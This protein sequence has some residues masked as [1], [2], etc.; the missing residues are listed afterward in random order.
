MLYQDLVALRSSCAGGTETSH[1]MA[2]SALKTMRFVSTQ[3]VPDG[4][5]EGLSV[6][7]SALAEIPILPWQ[8][9]D[10]KGPIGQ[11]E[12]QVVMWRWRE[13]LAK[14][15]PSIYELL[16]GQEDITSLVCRACPFP[17][18]YPATA[19]MPH[20]EFTATRADGIKVGFP[21]AGAGW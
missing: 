11:W 6:D 1:K 7:L 20:W 9:T 12:G 19:Q 13:Y 21:P 15:E 17:S 16:F 8:Y 3:D 2:N 4:A 10:E 14:L 5:C 18:P